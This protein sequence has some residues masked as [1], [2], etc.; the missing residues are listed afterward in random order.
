M[1]PDTGISAVDWFSVW[2]DAITKPNESTYLNIANSSQAK[3]TTAFLWIF[4]ASLL[5]GFIVLVVQSAY[6]TQMFQQFGV[7]PQVNGSLAS[8][9]VTV[10]CGAPIFGVISV[11]SFA[12]FVGVTQ[13]VAKM[14]G[15]TAT[16]DQL[17]YT[18]AAITAPFSLVS[19]V[20]TLLGAIPFIGM[21]FGIVSLLASFYILYLEALAIKSVNKFGWGQAVGTLALPLILICCCFAVGVIGLMRTLGPAINDTFNSIQY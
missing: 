3:S 20:L 7:D 21:C 15:G 10:I 5:Q 11:V 9:L 1:S 14:F 2:R 18:L 16:F 4:A 13:F 6:M 19:S 12:I 17:A 8:R